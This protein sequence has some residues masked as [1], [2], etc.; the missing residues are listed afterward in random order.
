MS[1]SLGLPLFAIIFIIFL[2]PAYAQEYS[3]NA[4]CVECPLKEAKTVVNTWQ[5]DGG[6]SITVTADRGSDTITVTGKTISDLTDVTF[7]VTS[8]S[9]NSVVSVVQVAPDNKKFVHEF[10]IGPIW[11]ESGFY[12]I[13]ASQSV[14]QNTWYTLSVEVKVKVLHRMVAQDI[15]E[16]N[17]NIDG[18]QLTKSFVVATNKKSYSMGETIQISGHVKTLA[19]YSQSVTIVVV[20]PDGN[21]VTIVQ[22]IPDKYGN[23][24]HTMKAGGPMTAPGD[25]QIIAKYGAQ[26]TTNDFRFPADYIRPNDFTLPADYIIPNDLYVIP[27]PEPVAVPPFIPEL[28]PIGAPEPIAEPVPIE[29]NNCGAGTH[30]DAIT[31][32]CK[33][34]YVNS[35][36]IK[37]YELQKQNTQLKIENKQLMNQ[38]NI[39]QEKLDT[40][41]SIINQQIKVMMDMFI[42]M[43][44]NSK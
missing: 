5:R 29:E 12:T 36:N 7:R 27:I 18:S 21:I 23:F 20:S 37:E 30:Y 33:L 25:Y 4:S 19:E 28:A 42:E 13:T 6:L 1:N 31:N 34:D 16:T 32:S 10:K 44:N 35:D 15:D 11:K 8:P 40:I 3:D 24:S 2:I 41:Q 9:G 38:I 43:K 26:K 22:V 39:L 17:Q 14:L